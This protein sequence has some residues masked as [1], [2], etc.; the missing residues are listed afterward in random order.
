MIEFATPHR[1]TSCRRLPTHA[2]TRPDLRPD[3]GSG[4]QDR[5]DAVST[6]ADSL[7]LP[8]TADA[9][10]REV[11]GLKQHFGDRDRFQ[12]GYQS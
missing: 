9:A 4:K 6:M 8:R 10:K 1:T 2:T 3:L 12:F 5:V 11:G 7:R